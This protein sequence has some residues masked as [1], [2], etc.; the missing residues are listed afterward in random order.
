MKTLILK[1]KPISVNA[2]YRGRRFLTKE[3]KATKEAMAWE[4]K[5]QIRSL[6]PYE[7]D[8]AM[9][10]V[11]Y[12]PNLRSDL[13]NLLKAFLDSLTGLLYKDDSQITELHIFKELDKKNPRIELSI[14]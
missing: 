5:S 3:G 11:F 8:I 2:M 1:T 14:I 10:V 6:K 4:I 9:N 7:G 13:D 12:V